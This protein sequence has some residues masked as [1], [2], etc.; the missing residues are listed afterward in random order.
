MAELGVEQAQVVIAKAMGGQPPGGAA[1]AGVHLRQE[2]LTS[3]Q[4]RGVL[5]VVAWNGG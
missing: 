5:C 4:G 1:V 3:P 2:G